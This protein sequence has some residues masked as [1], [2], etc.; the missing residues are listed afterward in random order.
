MRAWIQGNVLYIHEEDAPTYR[1][2]GGMVRNSYFWALKSI[3]ARARRDRPWEFEAEIWPALQ[4][5]LLSFLESGYLSLTEVQL[6][7]KTDQ[8]I[9]ENL[10]SVSTYLEESQ[11][12]E[13]AA[14][15]R[16]SQ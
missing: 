4:R 8:P 15:D 13:E 6:S 7:F 3:A 2:T 11:D 10:R 12:G 1:K 16:K 5:M 14:S 9:P